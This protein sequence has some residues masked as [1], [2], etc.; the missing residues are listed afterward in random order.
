MYSNIFK[1]IGFYSPLGNFCLF[2]LS[3]EFTEKKKYSQKEW[4]LDIV[5]EKQ[6]NKKQEML[7]IIIFFCASMWIFSTQF[8]DTF[9]WDLEIMNWAE[10]NIKLSIKSN[11]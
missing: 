9:T 3:T 2:V 1:M 10:P 5:L 8:H 11:P 6:D 7:I 4:C